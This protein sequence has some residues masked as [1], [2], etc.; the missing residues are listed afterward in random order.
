MTHVA[1][2]RLRR[3]GDRRYHR[4]RVAEADVADAAA[5]PAALA[6][7]ATVLR[8]ADV[9]D[10]GTSDVFGEPASNPAP[11]AAPALPPFDASVADL[12]PV[13]PID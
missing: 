8:A 11:A 9:I 4:H 1:A 6:A 10:G 3:A 2:H 5:T 13:V 7:D 12:Q